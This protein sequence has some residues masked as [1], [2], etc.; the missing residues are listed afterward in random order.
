MCLYEGILNMKVT[1]LGVIAVEPT[2][3]LDEGI[4]KELEL[5]CW[6]FPYREFQAE[7]Y[8]KEIFQWKIFPKR[9][10]VQ[11]DLLQGFPIEY[12]VIQC[13]VIL[14]WVN[15][16]VETSVFISWGGPPTSPTKN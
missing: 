14:Y 6:W 2:V 1:L 13:D 9:V 7:N 16:L 12:S 5:V 3:L 10:F 4:R 15:F 11:G 8:P